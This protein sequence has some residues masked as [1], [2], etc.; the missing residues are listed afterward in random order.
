MYNHLIMTDTYQLYLPYISK[1]YSSFSNKIVKD[2]DYPILGVRLP[3][4]RTLAKEIDELDFP[5]RYH[6][7]VLLRGFVIAFRRCPV[8]EKLSLITTQLPLLKSWD[9]VDSFSAALKFRKADMDEAYSYFKKLFKDERVFVRR[10]AIVWIMQN[11]KSFDD[12]DEMLALITSVKNDD[13]YVSMAI[14]WALCDFYILSPD[15]TL[16]YFKV[17]DEETRR[18]AR[19][20]CRDSYRITDGRFEED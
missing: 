6:E 9:E 16:P 13:Y 1:E 12:I 4:L 5:I 3:V 15:S 19:Q 11:K 14:A 17:V 18:R 7:D 10:L 2:V 8:K 20:K